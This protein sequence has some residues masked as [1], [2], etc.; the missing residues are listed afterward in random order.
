METLGGAG[1]KLVMRNSTI[2]TQATE[3]FSTGRDEQTLIEI[4]VVQ[5]ERELVK[6]C[7]SLAKFRLRIPPM[8]AGV[9]RIHVTF[10]IDADGILRVHASE[11]RSG[12]EASIEVVPVHGLTQEEVDQIY[13]DSL[14]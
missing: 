1:A 12:S 13:L 14:D 6:D 3:Y 10:L 8:P 5:G 11:E 7:R 2:P 9:P 4:H